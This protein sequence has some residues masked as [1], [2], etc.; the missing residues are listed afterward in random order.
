M[1][2]LSETF[3]FEAIIIGLTGGV[4]PAS[5]KN[6]W[7]S[8][9]A[10]HMRFPLQE[11]PATDWEARVDDLFEEG[12]KYLDNS[13]RRKYYDE[14]QDIIAEQVPLAFT[15]NPEAWYAVYTHV[16]NAQPTAFARDLL[17]PVDELWIDRP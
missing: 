13:E 2:Q 4:E 8:S 6:V 5:G 11:K 3:D 7:P 9:G 12:P 10:L 1:R 16:K 14:F 17:Y 15:V